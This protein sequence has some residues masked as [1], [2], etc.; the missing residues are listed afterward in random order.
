MH[1]DPVLLEDHPLRDT[2]VNRG[3]LPYSVQERNAT[4]DAYNANVNHL[5]MRD[6]RTHVPSQNEPPNVARPDNDD[7]TDGAW[8]ENFIDY[9]ALLAMETIHL[10]GKANLCHDLRSLVEKRFKQ[11]ETTSNRRWCG[12]HALATSLKSRLPEVYQKTFSVQQLKRIFQSQR[13]DN[14]RQDRINAVTDPASRASV[15]AAFYSQDILSVGQLALILYI[16][17]EKI[18]RRLTL[19]ICAVGRADT[20]LEDELPS[21]SYDVFSW[22]PNS[23]EHEATIIWAVYD[24]IAR[25]DQYGDA[26]LNNWSGI[27]PDGPSQRGPDRAKTPN[28]TNDRRARA[29]PNKKEKPQVRVKADPGNKQALIPQSGG[30]DFPVRCTVADCKRRKPFKTLRD[31]RYTP[32]SLS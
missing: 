1:I 10:S 29:P 25:I 22:P 15:T 2:S 4:I 9:P 6:L 32:P 28:S 13:F 17:G 24:N 5:V 14:I 30:V 31:L 12:I 16:V 19:G 23:D 21:A 27:A 7:A 18:G 11:Q 8:C 20:P 26:M 3:N